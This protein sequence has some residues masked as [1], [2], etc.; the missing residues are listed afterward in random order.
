[1]TVEYVTTGGIVAYHAEVM[2]ASGHSPLLIAPE[3]LESAIARP[4]ATA[5]G[6]EAFP[7]LAEKAG[8]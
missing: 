2:L 6:E 1:M 5:F 8:V 4:Q 3:K 7:T